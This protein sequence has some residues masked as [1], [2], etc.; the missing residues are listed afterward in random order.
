MPVFGHPL[1]LTTQNEDL[2][3]T[4]SHGSGNGQAQLPRHRHRLKAQ[5]THGA[6]AVPFALP[7]LPSARLPL[8][9]ELVPVLVEDLLHTSDR[10]DK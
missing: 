5:V 8:H 7:H 3:P 10:V 4:P 2:T 1:R 6:Q 9:S